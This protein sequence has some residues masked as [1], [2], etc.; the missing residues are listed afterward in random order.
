MPKRR[1]EKRQPRRAQPQHPPVSASCSVVLGNLSRECTVGHL[2]DFASYCGPIVR[3]DAPRRDPNSP[4][5]FFAVVTYSTAEAAQAAHH[6][7]GA[8]VA[9]SPVTVSGVNIV[10]NPITLEETIGGLTRSVGLGR[11]SPS[12]ATGSIPR[13]ASRSSLPDGTP[14]PPELRTDGDQPELVVV[15]PPDETSH[16]AAGGIEG[17]L[18]KAAQSIDR[19]RPSEKMAATGAAL[20]AGAAAVHYFKTKRKREQ[21]ER[22]RDAQALAMA[23]DHLFY[24]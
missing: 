16:A 17:A 22:R 21:R 15:Y 12:L 19:L 13:S 9:G 2:R 23:Y 3:L 5:H 24:G 8:E 11:L 4:G 1:S 18:R 10:E 7:A 14:S 20:L 6:L